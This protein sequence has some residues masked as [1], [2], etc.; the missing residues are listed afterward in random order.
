VVA[1]SNELLVNEIDWGIDMWEAYQS[2]L[3]HNHFYPD[4]NDFYDN[5]QLGVFQ[6]ESD[7]SMKQIQEISLAV[8]SNEIDLHHLTKK[9]EDANDFHLIQRPKAEV[10]NFLL[11]NYLSFQSDKVYNPFSTE[12]W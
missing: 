8:K 6:K 3:Y 2:S 1:M 5:Y 11:T 4:F 10:F 12:V 9:L 7:L